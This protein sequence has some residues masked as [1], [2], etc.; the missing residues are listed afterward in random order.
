MNNTKY[1]YWVLW[2]IFIYII[3]PIIIFQFI[4]NFININ[5]GIISLDIILLMLFSRYLNTIGLSILFCTIILIDVLLSS[6]HSYFLVVDDL[7]FSI[8]YLY[9]LK[10]GIYF[11]FVLFLLFLSLI[12]M[13]NWLLKNIIKPIPIWFS[14]TLFTLVCGL[15]VLNNSSRLYYFIEIP[16]ILNIE[17]NIARSNLGNAI[18]NLHRRF[19]LKESNNNVSD[20]TT[21]FR[22][23][24]N[25][26]L[27]N[28]QKE[29]PNICLVIMESFGVNVDSN[30]FNKVIMP[31]S[32]LKDNFIIKIG[33]EK[34]YG[35]TISAETRELLGLINIPFRKLKYLDSTKVNNSIPSILKKFGYVSY[36]YHGFSGKMF[37]NKYWWPKIGFDSSIF[38]ENYYELDSL[39]IG[40]LFRGLSDRFLIK[41]INNK[42][43][44]ANVSNPVFMYLLTL[45][46]HLPISQDVG[47]E[48]E[49]IKFDK[50][51]IPAKIDS[52]NYRI[53]HDIANMISKSSN[54]IFFI[55]GDHPPPL[56][57]KLSRYYNPKMIPSIII[58]QKDL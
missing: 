41:I 29:K 50:L 23:K 51:D 35:S 33:K 6:A 20:V 26:I 36:G 46:T 53:L 48:Y 31:I 8:K 55:V 39:Q 17:A 16:P 47:R 52:I 25:E 44:D 34:F 54:T 5:A 18:V 10:A 37:D 9:Q 28:S 2:S 43:S 58:E 22:I 24:V 45:N 3:F 27:H 21:N 19:S 42:I 11:L 4:S 49:I 12:W 7:F 1:S 40:S 13:V 14:I 32:T 30:N 38:L 15:D 57:D 56:G